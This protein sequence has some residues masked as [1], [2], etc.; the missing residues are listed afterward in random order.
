MSNHPTVFD[1]TLPGLG[2]LLGPR[3]RL[4]AVLETGSTNS[5]LLEACRNQAPEPQ[6][7]VAERQRAGRG[8]LGRSWE[9]SGSEASLTFSLAWPLAAGTPLDGLSLAV[10]VALAESLDPSDAGLRL[11]WPNDLWWQ[12]RKLGGVLIEA[13]TGSSGVSAVVVGVGLNL[14][15]PDATELP[16]TAGLRDLDAVWTAPLALAA[17][18][19]SLAALLEGWQGFTPDWQ[20]RFAARD[21]LAGRAVAG[22]GV[23]GIAEG[24]SRDG[25]LCLRGADGGLRL[26]RA[27]EA[28]LRPQEVRR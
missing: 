25:L 27:G 6:L 21:A 14:A 26:L 5:D 19:P 8:R 24:V 1:T 17:V 16:E 10:G 12:D 15:R 22:D 2:L 20:R 3:W 4:R 7:L 23:E 18:L 13:L 28:R 11:K 9:S